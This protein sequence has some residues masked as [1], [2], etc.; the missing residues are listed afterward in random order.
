M[1]VGRRIEAEEEEAGHR[2]EAEEAVIDGGG[3]RRGG[4]H[5]V[6]GR[7]AAIAQSEEPTALRTGAG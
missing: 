5:F 7:C 4:R 3:G 6:L 1:G 2:A